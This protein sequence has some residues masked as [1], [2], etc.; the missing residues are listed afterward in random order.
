MVQLIEENG[1]PN[2][3]NAAMV[4]TGTNVIFEGTSTGTQKCFSRKN[5][6]VQT[7]IKDIWIPEL[8]KDLDMVI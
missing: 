3:N 2:H 6:I 7:T 4:S 8:S 1:T 5:S